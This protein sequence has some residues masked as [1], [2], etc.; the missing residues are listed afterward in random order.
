MYKDKFAVATVGPNSSHVGWASS[1]MSG[2]NMQE[3]DQ[4]F[5][6]IDTTVCICV[7]GLYSL[8]VVLIGH[9]VSTI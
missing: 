6:N 5:L 8:L 4:M 2:L 7:N 3:N 1:T 9:C